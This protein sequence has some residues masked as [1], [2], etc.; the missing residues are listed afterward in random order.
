MVKR[1]TAFVSMLVALLA[2]GAS[3]R[4]QADDLLPLLG[5]DFREEMP[6]APRASGQ[7][8]LGVQFGDAEGSFDRAAFRIALDAETIGSPLCVKVTTRDGRYWSLNPFG[9]TASPPA[10]ARWISA[11][12]LAS[13]SPAMTCRSSRSWPRSS[14]IAKRTGWGCWFRPSCPV[15]P[16]PR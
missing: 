10:I 6:E 7:R 3:P 16:R 1:R 13:G 5:N 9:P 15:M 12:A 11:P 8:L 2:I 14:R 4:A